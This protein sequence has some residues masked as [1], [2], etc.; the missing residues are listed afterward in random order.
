ME[1]TK[2]STFDGNQFSQNE[3]MSPAARLILSPVSN[4]ARGISRP[5]RKAHKA[6]GRIGRFKHSLHSAYSMEERRWDVRSWRVRIVVGNTI[7]LGPSSERR[8]IDSRPETLRQNL[9]VLLQ[10][11][12]SSEPARTA[13]G[14][15][16]ENE[17]AKSWGGFSSGLYRL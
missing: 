17:V 6:C 1:Q 8:Q 12:A 2:P 10:T 16:L 4:R 5:H 15:V 7:T 9:R 11:A 13:D 3:W 14:C